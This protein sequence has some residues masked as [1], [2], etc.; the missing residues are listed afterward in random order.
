M[1]KAA[2]EAKKRRKQRE[3]LGLGA[4]PYTKPVSTKGA[5]AD[6]EDSLAPG[7]DLPV[8]IDDIST[9]CR[10][11]ATLTE[12]PAL[13]SMAATSA[14]KT[15]K[16]LKR[17][18]HSFVHAETAA[19]QTSN[20]S[21]RIS[22]ALS[23]GRFVDARVLLAEMAIRKVPAKLGAVQRWV[24]DCDA[25]GTQAATESEDRAEIWKTLEAILRTTAELP[26]SDVPGG[27]L[28]DHYGKNAEIYRHQPWSFFDPSGDTVRAELEAGTLFTPDQATALKAKFRIVSNTPGPQRQPPNHHPAIIYTTIPGS[29]P[30]TASEPVTKHPHPYVP[31]CFLLRNV[32][33]VTD[34]RSLLS[35]AEALG[36]LPDQPL[37]S[38]NDSILAHNVYWLADES[39]MSLL[40]SRVQHL[41]PPVIEGPLVGINPRFRMYR[42]EPGA[43]YRPHIDG[44][45]PQ[46]GLNSAG[47][48][49]Y[50][51]NAA[52]GRKVW[53]RL[54]FLV[55]LNDDFEGGETTYFLPRKESG[56]DAFPIAPRAGCVA[57]FPH[58]DAKGSLLHEGSGVTKGVKYIIR[59]DVLYEVG[60][61]A[62]DG[63]KADEN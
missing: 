7:L 59:T 63:D 46:S 38:K 50:D 12:H 56:I 32:L 14:S 37:D 33:T 52:T 9:T 58:G 55:Y 39:F 22:L 4:V 41:L 15:L 29:I 3:K 6:S 62:T 1:G 30:I 28:T 16:P 36:Y 8:S 35:H 43:V 10:V 45:W 2:Q 24:R 44:A 51:M 61:N 34:C 19:S 26:P 21:S 47:E 53:S 18:V 40:F 60:K 25:A 20:L 31:G 27:V 5:D 54:T 11:L 17:A 49:I 48:Y 13:L 42:Y 57:V 23:S